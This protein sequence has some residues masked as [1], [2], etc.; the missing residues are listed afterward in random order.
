MFF[1]FVLKHACDGETDGQNYDPQDRVSIA[2]SRGK[3][4]KII[5]ILE[6]QKINILFPF[7]HTYC[8]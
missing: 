1:L 5:N 3:M 2:A 8:Q 7:Q 4:K 6:Q